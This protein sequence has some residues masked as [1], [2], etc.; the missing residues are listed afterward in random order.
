M[1]KSLNADKGT[2]IN[3]LEIMFTGLNKLLDKQIEEN[4]K[5]G[6]IMAKGK[7]NETRMRYKEVKQVLHKM[8]D[9]FE[10]KG[11]MS[12]GICKTCTNFNSKASSV[13]YFGLCRNK[14]TKHEYD[15]CGQHSYKGGGF[16]R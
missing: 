10:I 3:E 1:S 9:Y 13:G 4:P 16:G 14:D 7:V 12:L 11:C 6:I 2:T 15:T 8:Q 5:S